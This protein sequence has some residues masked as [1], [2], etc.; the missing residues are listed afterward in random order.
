LENDK[1]LS[2]YNITEGCTIKYVFQQASTGAAAEKKEEEEE[3]EE[4]AEK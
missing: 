3:D 4:D 1:K 2:D